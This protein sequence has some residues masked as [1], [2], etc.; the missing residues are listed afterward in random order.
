MSYHA[1]LSRALVAVWIF[2]DM[3]RRVGGGGTPPANSAPKHRSEQP[4]S[5]FVS[6]SEIIKDVF[7]SILPRLP[8]VVKGQI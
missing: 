4:K 3:R 2:H 1:I 8:E 5:E 6:S 7:R